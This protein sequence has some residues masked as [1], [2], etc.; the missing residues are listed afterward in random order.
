MV[1]VKVIKLND[2]FCGIATEEEKSRI[3][4]EYEAF[5]I[6]D[7][8]ATKEEYKELYALNLETHIWFVPKECCEIIED[9]PI[10]VSDMPKSHYKRKLLLVE[11][12]SVDIDQI[13]EDFGIDCIVYRQGANKPE[14]LEY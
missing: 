5:P 6:N 4:N 8:W 1:K 7:K 3:G 12:G 2:D 11:D 13:E 9:S 10:S 14:W